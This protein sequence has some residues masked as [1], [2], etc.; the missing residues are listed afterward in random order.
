MSTNDGARETRILRAA[1]YFPVTDVAALGG[2]YETV[3]GFRREYAAGDP[4][5]FAI[6]SRDGAP[7][8]FRRVSNGSAIRPVEM[9]GGTWDVFFWVS[10]VDLLFTEL[11]GRGASVVHA[12]V[13]QP[14]GIREFAIRDPAGH[15]LGF[16]QQEA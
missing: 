7:L 12:P 15:V 6:Y 1:P 8:M 2:Y 13:L 4:P 9:Q 14:Y 5:E 11:R 16:G 10:D 3:L